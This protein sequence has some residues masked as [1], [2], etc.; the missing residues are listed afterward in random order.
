MNRVILAFGALLLTACPQ[1]KGDDKASDFPRRDPVKPPPTARASDK[2]AAAPAAAPDDDANAKETA[3]P[4][5]ANA[6][7][8]FAPVAAGLTRPDAGPDER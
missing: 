1:S 3:A 2:A 6:A 5:R 8:E 7:A 4:T